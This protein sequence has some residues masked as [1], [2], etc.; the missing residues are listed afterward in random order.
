M[1]IWWRRT[2]ISISLVALARVRSTI[3]LTSFDNVT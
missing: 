2:R 1:A 3:Q